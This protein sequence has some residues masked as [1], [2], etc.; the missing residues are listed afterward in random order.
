MNKEELPEEWKELIIL[1]VYKKGDKTDCNNYRGI[2]F[3]SSTCKILANILLTGLTL[4][5]EETVT[6]HIFCVHQILKK[7]WE[8]N[9]VVHQLLVDFKKC[10]VSVRREVLYNIP[11]VSGVQMK[12]VRLIKMCLNET[13]SK[14][15]VGKTFI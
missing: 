15:Q 9:E 13:C 7:N 2:S 6:D 12:M 5:A 1:P 14:V 3:L 4:Y 11:N 8:Y 10:H